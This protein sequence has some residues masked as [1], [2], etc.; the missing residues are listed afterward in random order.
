M[1]RAAAAD[2]ALDPRAQAH[3]G[4][5][6][7]LRSS[8]A[9]ADQAVSDRIEVIAAGLS[10]ALARLDDHG[11][12]LVRMTAALEQIDRGSQVRVRSSTDM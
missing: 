6:P 5:L 11:A 1:A 7:P 4:A 10:I 8:S 3:A 2:R 12:L 9:Q